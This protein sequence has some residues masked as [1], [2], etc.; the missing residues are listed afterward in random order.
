VGAGLKVF[1]VSNTTSSTFAI[2]LL[3]GVAAEPFCVF[4]IVASVGGLKISGIFYISSI[5]GPLALSAFV[6]TSSIEGN[7]GVTAG[8]SVLCVDEIVSFVSAAEVAPS[9]NSGIAVGSM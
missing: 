3:L 9:P 2:L 6:S 5:F 4:G 8:S 1:V 7:F